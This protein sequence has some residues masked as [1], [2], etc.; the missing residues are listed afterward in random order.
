MSQQTNPIELASST[1]LMRWA[2]QERTALMASYLQRAAI[3]IA[4]SLGDCVRYFGKLVRGAAHELYL[5]NA[6]RTLQQFDDR[7]DRFASGRDRTRSAQWPVGN[8]EDGRK[9]DEESATS[10]CLNH[11]RRP[12]CLWLSVQRKR[13]PTYTTKIMEAEMN[14]NLPFVW[15]KNYHKEGGWQEKL[16]EIA[17]ER[18]RRYLS[19]A[20]ATATRPRKKSRQRTHLH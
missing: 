7:K 3:G 18:A 14:E 19:R 6:T 8:A 4:A 20:A 13:A 12:I 5:R 1:Q 9:S 2:R 10:R 17:H 16:L 15:R 11:P